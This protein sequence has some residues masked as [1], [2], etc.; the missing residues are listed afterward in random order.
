MKGWLR[1]EGPIECWLNIAQPIGSRL[2]ADSIGC[3]FGLG[4]KRKEEEDIISE[5]YI[6][7]YLFTNIYIHIHV[8]VGYIYI[9]IRVDRYV[10][11][12]YYVFTLYLGNAKHRCIMFSYFRSQHGSECFKVKDVIQSICVEIGIILYLGHHIHYNYNG[13]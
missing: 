11:L 10:C 12:L 6:N 5:N 1:P 2:S 9:Y 8:Y 3:R 7:I 13:C 4:L